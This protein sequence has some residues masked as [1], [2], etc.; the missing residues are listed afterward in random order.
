MAQARPTRIQHQ[1]NPANSIDD[2]SSEY[3]GS[4]E[5]SKGELGDK[6]SEAEACE[7]SEAGSADNHK[8]CSNVESTHLYNVSLTYCV[9]KQFNSNLTLSFNKACQAELAKGFSQT[10][11]ESY[12]DQPNEEPD[13]IKHP[14]TSEDEDY[15]AVRRN[16]PKEWYQPDIESGTHTNFIDHGTTVDKNGYP[17]HPNGRTTFVHLPTDEVGNFGKVGFSKHSAI[18][19]AGA[20]WTWKITRYFCLGVLTC[21]NTA[22]TWAGSP[23]TC[24]KKWKHLPKTV[25]KMTCPGLAGH[26]LGKVSHQR[27]EEAAIRIDQHCKGWGLL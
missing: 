13:P 18:S 1:V 14:S 6:D 21:D 16:N 5:I 9:I 3:K 2:S 19:Y 23:P 7:D 12:N 10:P 15:K 17:Y 4:D 27:C 22:C 8:E 11:F 24:W 26:C 25:Q 20:N